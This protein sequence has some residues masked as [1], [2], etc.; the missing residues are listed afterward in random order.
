[1]QRVAISLALWLTASALPAAET[2]GNFH[3]MGIVLE[4]PGGLSPGQVNRVGLSLLNGKSARRLLDAVQLRDESFYA[5]SG[6]GNSSASRLPPR[7]EGYPVKT[8]GGTRYGTTGWV[9]FFHNTC[10]TSVPNTGAFRVQEAQWRK[11]TLANNIWQGTRDGFVFWRDRISPISMNKD[12]LHVKTGVL[13][14]VRKT[15]YV[16]LSQA[17]Q[18]LPF[19]RGVQ[20]GDPRFRDPGQGD[21]RLQAGSPAIDAGVMI[22][23]VNGLRFLGKAPDVGALESKPGS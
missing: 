20:I 6:F 1:M 13:A 7:F 18:R 17:M 10:H 14:K 11:L 5:V 15:G 12:L 16:T 3:T 21:F 23:G 22:P 2:I 19:L 8:N 9:F 4:L